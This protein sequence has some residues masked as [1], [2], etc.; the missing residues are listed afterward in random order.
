M[1][2][3]LFPSKSL[4]RM[5]EEQRIDLEKQLLLILQIEIDIES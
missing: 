2:N 5:K 1:E 4:D 3:E